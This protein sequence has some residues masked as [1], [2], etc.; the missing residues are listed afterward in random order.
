MKK[1]LIIIGSIVL[2]IAAAM[3]VAFAI[4]DS[5]NGDYL[6]T[7]VFK[8]SDASAEYTG[9]ALTSPRWEMTSGTLKE[10]HIANVSVTGSVTNAGEA[11]NTLSVKILDE[12]GKDITDRYNI[13]LEEGILSV[14]KR[15][16]E[17]VTGS[18]QK[19]YDGTPLVANSY[20]LISGNLVNG[21][22]IKAVYSGSQIN[23]GT[24]E[25]SAIIAVFDNNGEDVSQNYNVK[26]HVGTLTVVKRHLSLKSSTVERVYNG[27]AL[28]NDNISVVEGSVATDQTMVVD[29]GAKLTGVGEMINKFTV[30]ISDP[31]GID[32]TENYDIS[33]NYGVLR[34]FA[35]RLTVYTG[36]DTKVYD[37]TDFIVDTYGINSGVLA[38]GEKLVPAFSTVARNVGIYENAATFSVVNS[39]GIDTTKNYAITVVSGTVEILERS[40]IIAS[41]DDFKVYDGTPLEKHEVILLEGT[42]VADG[43]NLSVVYTGTQTGHGTS[44]NEFTAVIY[45]EAGEDVTENY[46]ITCLFGNL[47]VSQRALTLRSPDKSKVYDGVALG[48]TVD[49]L[50]VLGSL[51]PEH[52]FEIIFTGEQLSVGECVNSFEIRVYD[53]NGADVTENYVIESIFGKLTVT[54][55]YLTIKTN[56]DSKIYDGVDFSCERYEIIF[57][58]VPDGENLNAIFFTV[59]RD[60]GTYGNP[61]LFTVY[62]A[63]GTD[64]TS[65]YVI[66]V[67]E[68]M[69]EIFERRLI[70]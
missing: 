41:L 42:S 40:L 12:D 47:S 61:A 70:I 38:T 56:S 4:N 60:V 22:S 68:G 29:A 51:A 9:D 23:V 59:E 44:K 14:G 21:H 48:C 66:T 10:G 37:G 17:V 34:V 57:G 11:K 39:A 19:E 62:G 36:S 53:G 25:C 20:E 13:Q 46:N 54:P 55:V 64:T 32:V 63:D 50:T 15:N 28:S 6:D 1:I 33:Y 26:C 3:A 58:S 43:Q 27:V 18:I 5:N 2:C 67:E 49:E 69:L 65:N 7:L 16:L 30:T 24:S 31:A 45:D 35:S 52:R 8:S